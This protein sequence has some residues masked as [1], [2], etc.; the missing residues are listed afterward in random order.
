MYKTDPTPPLHLD[1]VVRLDERVQREI[2]IENLLV[3]I[4]FIIVKIGW[5]GLAPWEFE[6][7]FPG[8]LTCTFL[9]GPAGTDRRRA[10]MQRDSTDPSRPLGLRLS[11]TRVYEPQIRA[12]LGTAAYFCK[13]VCAQLD[14]SHSG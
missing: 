13:V 6:F 7:P 10:S 2:F 12:R 1:Y 3:R 5:T 8:S 14:E 9:S 4:H 11:D